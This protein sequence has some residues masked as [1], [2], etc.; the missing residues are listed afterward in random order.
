MLF[1]CS[2]IGEGYDDW[3]SILLSN[4]CFFVGLGCLFCFDVLVLLFLGCSLV[5]VVCRMLLVYSY[6]CSFLL[7]LWY[8]ISFCDLLILFGWFELLWVGC[9]TFM[10]VG[11]L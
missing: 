3:F 7:L 2:F 4:A 9:L 5:C 6:D 11:V 1:R 10:F 8:W